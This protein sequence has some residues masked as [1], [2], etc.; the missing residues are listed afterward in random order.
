MKVSIIIPVYRTEQ[1]LARCVESVKAQTFAA[2][3]L[4]LVDDGS[5]D[6]APA[7]CDAYAQ[8]DA[9]IKVIHQPNAGLS[10]ARNSGLKV[11]QGEYVWFIDSDDFVA[12]DTLEAAVLAIEQYDKE[13]AFVE[14]PVCIAY[15][16]PVKQ[17]MRNFESKKYT[18]PW[19]WWFQAE[20]YTHCYAWNKLFRRSAIGN[21]RFEKRIFEDVFF[22][23]SL[24]NQVQSFATIPQGLYYYS[25]NP[26]G[27]TA[28]EGRHL[29]DLLEAYVRVS[30]QLQWRRPQGVSAQQF[31]RY[32]GQMLNVQIDVYDRCHK[33]VLLR[34]LPVGHTPKLL[35]QRLLGVRTCCWLINLVKKLCKHTPS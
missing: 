11:A 15:G 9:R 3:E 25:Y 6:G 2:W 26:S 14:F 28:N 16:H 1:T 17:R 23:H 5:D 21:L 7:L 35:L 34:S 32:Y 19:Q 12:P 20:G 22:M 31:A 13:V 33:K 18:D 30:N 8:K 24:L 29:L 4:I 10:A 27:I